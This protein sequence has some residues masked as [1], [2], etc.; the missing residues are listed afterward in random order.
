MKAITM[1]LRAFTT[2]TKMTT[3]SFVALLA[4]SGTAQ[5]QSAKSAQST[6]SSQATQ[7]AQ[8]AQAG[9]IRIEQARA[10]PTV[11]GQTSGA[12]YLRL[13]NKGNSGDKLVSAS[14]PMAKSV[15]IHT[16]SM[17]GNVMKMRE[18]GTLDLKPQS[19]ID[20]QPGAGYHIMLIGLTAPLKAGDKFPMT[21]VF[22]K[23]GKA[24]V[25]VEVGDVKAPAK[26][27]H[28]HQGGH[29]H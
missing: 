14:S 4:V 26:S 10:R 1:K 28:D 6:Q 16:M 7:S 19:T 27:A 25:S 8:Q 21:L 29:S 23:A 17:E 22:E 5:A 20:M 18:V 2:L 13:E 11:S 15:E 24:S 9:Q 12:A 3:V